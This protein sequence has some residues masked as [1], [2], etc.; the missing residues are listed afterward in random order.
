MRIAD[1]IIQFT[2]FFVPADRFLPVAVVFSSP[3][4][5]FTVREND[6]NNNNGQKKKNTPTPRT[7]E[8]P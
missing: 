4:Y 7:N 1:R 3:F 5:S 2:T 6:D 8:Y